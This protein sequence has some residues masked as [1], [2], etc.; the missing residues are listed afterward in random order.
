MDGT[1]RFE[2]RRRPIRS[3]V[4]HIVVYASSP[5]K[6]ILG[7]VKVSSIESGSP[8]TVWNQTKNLAG[9]SKT[10]YFKY[11]AGATIAYAIA[12]DPTKTIRL[13][14]HVSPSEIEMDFV[15]PQSFK[16]V[17]DSFVQILLNNV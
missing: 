17:G 1:K 5:C 2:F 13:K 11:F 6:K 9:I 16:Y 4:T 12:I 10:D 8:G 7:V 15:V 3:D 14:R